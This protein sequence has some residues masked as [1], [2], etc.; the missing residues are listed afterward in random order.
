MITIQAYGVND[1]YNSA[2]WRM[3][4]E[5]LLDKSR[6]GA[7]MRAP[8]PVITAYSAP[9]ERVLFDAKRDANPFFHFMEGLWMLAG[10]DDVASLEKYNSQIGQFSDDGVT[11]A[12]AY[13]HRWVK[14]FQLDQ[15][16]WVIN[17][18]RQVPDSRRA[19]LQMWDALIDPYRVD[20]GG[21]D[22]P[23]NTTIYFSIRGDTLDMTVCCRSNDIIWGCYGA[24]VVHMTMLQE[25]VALMVG[26]RMGSYY[27]FSNDWH[28]YERH[29]GLLE[30]KESS[31]TEQYPDTY[32]LLGDHDFPI[33]RG[34]S[35][36]TEINE[37]FDGSSTIE[38]WRYG[39][40]REV[41]MNMDA[42]WKYHKEG[43]RLGALS[44]CSK[45]KAADWR[46]ACTE[47]IDRRSYK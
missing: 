16:T 10:R 20:H 47:W 26:K 7:V 39:I 12:G 2:L 33:P 9:V 24:N 22:V 30:S 42:A 4:T 6:N 38:P 21:K 11:L 14:H 3:S 31:Y 13:G 46:K 18:L 40:I 28:M 45:I 5:G 29:F 32:P 17:H 37:F 34:H 8:T 41:A 23:C 25:Y 1:A 35:L 19:V 44:W 15:I 36:A 43:N 27:Q